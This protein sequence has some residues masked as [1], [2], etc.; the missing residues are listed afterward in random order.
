MSHWRKNGRHCSAIAASIPA[1][2]QLNVT[3]S[4]RRREPSVTES[5]SR[6]AWTSA[7]ST[8]THQARRPPSCSTNARAAE[9]NGVPIAW[10]S[11]TTATSSMYWPSPRGTIR[12]AVPHPACRP[13]SALARPCSSSSFAPAPSRSGTAR[14]TWSIS[15][16]V[17]GFVPRSS[18]P[19]LRGEARPSEPVALHPEQLRH[20]GPE[21]GERLPDPQVHR[22]AP[23]E[24]PSGHQRRRVFAGVVGGVVGGITAVVPGEEQDPI[25]PHRLD[26]LGQAPVELLDAPRV[27]AR[28]L[29]VPV[30]RVEV[31]QV[32]HHQ[33]VV[34][35][36]Q[37]LHGEVD[38]VIVRFGMLRLRETMP[39]ED[40]RDL[41]H[42]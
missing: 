38:A 10:V 34:L 17:T 3:P 4:G 6:S 24:Q 25:L 23:A 1:V 20:R 26:Q 33:N 41:P 29:P 39:G 21:V 12:F 37:V 18:Q 35:A 9:P 14:S 5:P 7:S 8:A 13:P 27:P 22:V 40:V 19:Q 2:R 11:S 15:V 16:D 31:D 42:P 32:G 30:L 36:P 28:V